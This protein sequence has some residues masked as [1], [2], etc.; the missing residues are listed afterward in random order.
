[1]NDGRLQVVVGTD[2]LARGLDI[3][4]ITHVFNL[5]LPASVNDYIHRAGRIGRLHQVKFNRR[6]QRWAMKLPAAGTSDSLQAPVEAPA[7]PSSESWGDDSPHAT[8]ATSTT[9]DTG[10]AST[11]D[12]GDQPSVPASPT[13]TAVHSNQVKLNYD[14]TS[15]RLDLFQRKLSRNQAVE[16]RYRSNVVVTIVYP[17]QVPVLLRYARTLNIHLQQITTE[18]GQLVF[19]G[20]DSTSVEVAKPQGPQGTAVNK[21]L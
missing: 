15:E 2:G 5:S 8:T 1:M 12:S 16:D 3:K 18:G 19:V 11:S 4:G 9:T 6:E 13:A 17:D 14:N 21:L 10:A 20:G 7:L